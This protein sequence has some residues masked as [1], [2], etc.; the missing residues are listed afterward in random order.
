M[1]AHG[2]SSKPAAQRITV[3]SVSP[4]EEDHIRLK[5][6][7]SSPKRT[8]HSNLTFTMIARKTISEAKSILGQG[9]ISIVLCE[10]DL[11]PGSWK[12]LLDS[13]EGLPAP[14]PVI[15]ASRIA[16]ERMWAE[17]LNLGGYDVL[18]RPLSGEEVIRSVTS[19][20]SL[21]QHQLQFRDGRAE[22][23]RGNAA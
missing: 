6:I 14:P 1:T 3:L 23:V 11:A 4:A 10:H 9:R 22:K 19:A 12:E 17:V 16:D 8:I 2:K 15:V 21:R 13:A 7:L 18:A 5:E 20:W